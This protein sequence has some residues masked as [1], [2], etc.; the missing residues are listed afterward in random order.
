MAKKKTTKKT[1][2]KLSLSTSDKVGIGV[3]LTTAAVAAAGAYFLYGSPNASKNRKQVKSW[4]LKAK[5]EVLEA[6]EQAEAMT[7][8]EF[9]QLVAVVGSTYAAVQGTSKK[10]I[11]DFKREMMD[12]WGKFTRSKAVKG[13]SSAK[14]ATKKAKKVA[15]KVAKKAA[16]KTAKKTTKKAA[17]KSGKK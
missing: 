12:N 14:K 11:A 3:G 8:A 7:E 5:A 17:K 15:K 4:M 10:D 13:T 9:K 16:K 1:N 2:R 6:M